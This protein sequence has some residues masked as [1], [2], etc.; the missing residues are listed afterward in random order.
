MDRIVHRA[1]GPC[2]VVETQPLLE[3]LR[4]ANFK[5]H[6][7]V[8]PE[9]IV[10]RVYEHDE[11]L[12][13]K[14]IDLFRLVKSTVPVPRLI[15]P[16]P[17]G[18]DGLPPFLVMEYVE[19]V[20]FHELKRRG[21]KDAIGE[22]AFSIGETLARIGRFT[23]SKP[24]WLGPG[25]TVSA[26]L[27]EGDDPIPRFVELCLNTPNLRV[28]MAP[29]L[30]ERLGAFVWSRAPQFAELGSER[31]LVH[32]DFGKRNVLVRQDR[33]GWSVAAVLDWEFAVSGSPLADLGRFLR[34]ERASRPIAEPHLSQ[35]YLHA[36]GTLPTH[37][38]EQARLLDVVALCESLT[39]D[40][41][42]DQ[43]A[44]E[45]LELIRAVVEVREAVLP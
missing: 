8:Q 15:H 11:S 21:D 19:G 27:L 36:G 37:W 10:V 13:Q 12:C 33:G 22:A 16:E 25:A 32:G 26:P 31:S 17:R 14:E 35:G 40:D 30:R 4:N 2:K 1:C 29:E 24:G 41:L 6:L 39:H 7:D 23:F 3:G 20:S 34:Y 5:V 18:M 43:I 45:L 28:R 38:R 42:P 44:A 9:W